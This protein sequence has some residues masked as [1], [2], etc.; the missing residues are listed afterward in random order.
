MRH[1]TGH[2]IRAPLNTGA[3]EQYVVDAS[4]FNNQWNGLY[5]GA[6]TDLDQII[7]LGGTQ[8]NY[9]AIAKILKGYT[10][11]LL[12]DEFGDIP[13]TEALERRI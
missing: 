3:S 11:L 9:I 5:A 7:K 6:L 8:K 1:N 12:T 10:Y 2:K 13:Y 4:E